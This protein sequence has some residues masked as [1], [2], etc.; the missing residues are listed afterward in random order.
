MLT[1]TS[2]H[3]NKLLSIYYRVA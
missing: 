1:V 2:I 3:Y